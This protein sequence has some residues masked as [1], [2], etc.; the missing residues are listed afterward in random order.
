[1]QKASRFF[2]TKFAYF[3]W[4]N[5]VAAVF[6]VDCIIDGAQANAKPR[7]NEIRNLGDYIN[8]ASVLVELRRCRGRPMPPRS[9]LHA[10]NLRSIIPWPGV[11]RSSNPGEEA[12][13]VAFLIPVAIACPANP[14]ATPT[15]TIPY[16]F[17]INLNSSVKTNKRQFHGFE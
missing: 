4:S 14:R 12:H 1:M 11:S 17:L 13:P 16:S 9:T 8:L 3:P 15:V 5:R 2:H 10:I 7:Y 6:H